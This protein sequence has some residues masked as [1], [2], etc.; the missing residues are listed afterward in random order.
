[1]FARS[2]PTESPTGQA[3]PP[4]RATLGALAAL[5]LIA[6]IAGAAAP[7]AKAPP[8][9]SASAGPAKITAF[10]RERGRMILN[11]IEDDLRKYYY[12]TTF[13]G[14]DVD[15]LFRSAH[16]AIDE[17]ETT[18]DL[19]MTIARPLLMLNDSHTIFLPPGRVAR[20][21][22]GWDAQMVGD[23]CFVSAVEPGSDAETKGL[24]RGD[25]IVAF[26]GDRPTRDT[27]QSLLYVHRFLAPQT[28]TPLTIVRPGGERLDLVVHART[29]AGQALTDYSSTLDVNAATRG[30][31]DQAW[32]GRHRMQAFGEELLVW[33]MPAFD[34]NADEV[35]TKILRQVRKYPKLIIDLRGNGGGAVEG[36][37]ALVGGLVGP[38]TK[39]AEVHARKPLPALM[40]KKAGDVYTGTIVLLIDSFSASASE[41]LARTLQ[42]AG[43]GKVLG[44]RSAGAVME[45][46]IY[47]RMAGGERTGVH[48]ATSIT[49]A[50]LIMGDGKSLE[51]TGVTPDETLLPTG[52][53]LA[54]GRDPVLARAL[55][56]CGVDISPEQAGAMFPVE[57]HR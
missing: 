39:I 4:A 51:K 29:I 55:S 34:M 35:R 14:L 23:R 8:G 10:E 36:L 49:I 52:D 12:D 31:A 32:L 47:P 13:H 18:N 27:L 24:R 41:L 25:E 57:W 50:D 9:K 16:E 20:F 26:D 17:A 42:L 22:F 38:D 56:L 46:N 5:V 43:R 7:P 44:D 37:Q 48:F 45:S 6:G 19:M 30:M 28:R 15:R 1:M 21:E 2:R 11:A 54:S 3:A 40:G 53:D 33:K